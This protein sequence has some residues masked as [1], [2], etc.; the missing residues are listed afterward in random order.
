MATKKYFITYGRLDLD[1]INTAA[2]PTVVVTGQA[3]V[4]AMA[5]SFLSVI[6]DD[7]GRQIQEVRDWDGESPFYF[8]HQDDD[9]FYFSVTP[10]P[11]VNDSA[12]ISAFDDFVSQWVVEDDEDSL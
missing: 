6:P 3:R 1:A 12:A 7:I 4:Q 8:C 11:T 5:T 9:F 2:I 10:V